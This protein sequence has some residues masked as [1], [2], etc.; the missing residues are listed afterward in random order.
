MTSTE[1]AILAALLHADSAMPSG[2]F[3]FSWGLEELYEDRLLTEDDRLDVILRWYLTT[4]WASF[5]RFFVHHSC[6]AD[7]DSRTELDRRFT[8]ASSGAAARESGVRAGRAMLLAWSKVGAPGASEYLQLVKSGDA[9]GNLP[10][11]Q[12]IVYAESGMSADHAVAVSGWSFLSNLASAAVRLGNIGALAAQKS[13]VNT[14]P[15]LERMIAAPIPA[16]PV[17]WG[18]L[19][20]IAMERHARRTSRL[21]AS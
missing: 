4:R 5:D 14:L 12:G 15:D 11:V 2:S 9:D 6:L 16:T 7:R 13:L 1:G 19:Q 18:V 8:A 3:A 21:F 17:S 10:V 20:D